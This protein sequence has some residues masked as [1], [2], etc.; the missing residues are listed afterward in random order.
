MN[1]TGMIKFEVNMYVSFKL[2]VMS[3]KITHGRFGLMTATQKWFEDYPLDE[4]LRKIAWENVDI[5]EIAAVVA[6][7]GDPQNDIWKRIQ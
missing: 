5:C 6:F 1:F 4:R 7:R 2:A 3:E